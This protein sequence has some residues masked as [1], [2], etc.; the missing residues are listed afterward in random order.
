[1]EDAGGWRR[2]RGWIQAAHPFPLIMVVS[3]TALI[4]IA[5]SV[6]GLA[7]ARL[8]LLTLAMVFAQLA[9]GWTNDY[10]DRETDARFQPEKPVPSGLVGAEQLRWAVVAVMIAALAVGLT[11]GAEAFW[12]LVVG[13]GAGLAYDFGVKDTRLS[14]LPFIVAFA[15]L[16]LY[17]WTALDVYRSELLWLYVVGPPLVVAAH[18]ANTLPDLE[19]DRSAG[20]KSLNVALGRERSLALLGL[21]LAAPLGLLALSLAFVEYDGAVLAVVLG[22]YVLLA[23][24]AMGLDWRSTAR[25]WVVWGFRCVVLASVT[26]AVGWL[27]AVR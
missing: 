12:L 24:V 5:S 21:C 27:V 11:L 25:E 15:G 6:D 26:L 22:V 2:L 3:L 4:G 7:V 8:A 1:M 19:A 20:R 17:V 10:R 9:I 14:W 18:I 16:P 23:A 13:M